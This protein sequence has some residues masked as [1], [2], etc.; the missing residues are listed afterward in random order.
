[1]EE[2]EREIWVGENRLYL[3]EDNI[4]YFTVVGEHNEKVAIEISEAIMKL[5]ET[6]ERKVNILIFPE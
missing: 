4:I 3:G 5:G 1:M 2:K 6:V